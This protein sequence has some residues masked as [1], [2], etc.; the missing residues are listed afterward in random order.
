MSS[1]ETPPSSPDF[2]TLPQ[3]FYR[4]VQQKLKVALGAEFKCVHSPIEN[5]NKANYKDVK[6]FV[7]EPIKTGTLT[8]VVEALFGLKTHRLEIDGSITQPLEYSWSEI[9]TNG[10]QL[11]KGNE[12]VGSGESKDARKSAIKKSQKPVLANG[13]H[14]SDDRVVQITVQAW[15]SKAELDNFRNSKI[16]HELM[17]LLSKIIKHHG[18]TYNKKGLL[19]RISDL[20]SVKMTAKQT[21]IMKFLGLNVNKDP[22][23]LQTWDDL[24]SFVATCRFH[25][26]KRWK[27]IGSAA[28]G[29]SSQADSLIMIQYFTDIYLPTHSGKAG[30]KDALMTHPQI[31]QEAKSNA[32]FDNIF[33]TEFAKKGVFWAEVRKHMP[34]SVKKPELTYAIK[35]LKKAT[36]D[37]YEGYGDTNVRDHPIKGVDEL[38]LFY[39]DGKRPN[40]DLVKKRVNWMYAGALQKAMDAAKSADRYKT[41][42]K[43]LAEEEAFKIRVLKLVS[44]G[45][46]GE[47]R[48]PLERMLRRYN[49]AAKKL[50]AKTT[51]A[52]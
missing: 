47:D 5:S 28:T 1:P 9:S 15:Q 45:T 24:M 41:H 49:K 43:N 48:K 22:A 6:M 7:A 12:K 42:K 23:E 34:Q 18:L 33:S 30:G 25:E 52:K 32:E 44:N 51:G 3:S 8:E 2:P 37:N 19:L 4:D 40:D 31:L 11:A 20:E 17:K 14:Q 21:E 27:V 39:K 46:K 35:G 29:N 16:N 36:F 26:P 38:Q 50:A 13:V 10:L